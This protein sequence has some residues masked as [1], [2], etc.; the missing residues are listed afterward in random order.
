LKNIY[1]RECSTF[2]QKNPG[3]S[4]TK[5]QVAALTYK[6]YIKA[7]SVWLYNSEK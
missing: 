7:M 6:P 1:N 3:M 2:M 5:Y 4:I